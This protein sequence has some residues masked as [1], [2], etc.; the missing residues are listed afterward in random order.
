M[1]LT[2]QGEVFFTQINTPIQYSYNTC[3]SYQWVPIWGQIIYQIPSVPKSAKLTFGYN[4]SD[5]LVPREPGADDYRLDWD[6]KGTPGTY[7][8]LSHRTYY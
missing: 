3:I 6:I 5:A 2:G 8:F 1:A 7:I 4:S